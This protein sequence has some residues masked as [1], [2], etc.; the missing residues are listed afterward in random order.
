MSFDG[1]DANSLP[2]VV[3]AVFIEKSTPFLSEFL[4]RLA[5]LNYPKSRILLFLH[6]KESFHKEDV[7]DFVEKFQEAYKGSKLILS[8]QKVVDERKA[9]NDAM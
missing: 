8:S 7:A 4:K 5:D 1:T 9:R 3:L 2:L 6:N